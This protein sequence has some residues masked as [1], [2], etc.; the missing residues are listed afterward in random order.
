MP[1][2]TRRDPNEPDPNDDPLPRYRE[3]ELPSYS[4]A[5]AYDATQRDSEYTRALAE[6]LTPSWHPNAQQ[7]NSDA[8]GSN[9]TQRNALFRQL[10]NEYYASPWDPNPSRTATELQ[11]RDAFRR[12]ADQAGRRRGIATEA[13]Y[14]P[15]GVPQNS[16]ADAAS[17]YQPSRPMAR[18]QA[19]PLQ[20]DYVPQGVPQNPFA[21]AAS[22]YQ[23][24]RQPHQLEARRVSGDASRSAQQ[25]SN[26]GSA[27][28]KRGPTPKKRGPY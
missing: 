15:Q 24:P 14:A 26:R 3:I 20:A 23:P 9:E 2:R 13:D 18:R 1:P 17:E 8:T 6:Y 16:F 10:E 21:E 27:P 12:P 7:P 25:Q 19:G 28:K 5:T 4:E 22:E 11:R